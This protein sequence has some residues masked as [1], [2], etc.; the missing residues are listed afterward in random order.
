MTLWSSVE[1]C[2]FIHPKHSKLI[3][4][5]FWTSDGGM[6]KQYRYAPLHYAVWQG[7]VSVVEYLLDHGA[8]VDHT[9]REVS[10]PL[11]GGWSYRDQSAI[12]SQI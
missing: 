5:A 3:F 7:H 10:L 6:S 4:F 12:H 1:M 8:N 2:F 9:K 11:C